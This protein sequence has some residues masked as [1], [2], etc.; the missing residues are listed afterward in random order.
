MLN[1]NQS[2]RAC[3]SAMSET[4]HNTE[5]DSLL[6]FMLNRILKVLNGELDRALQ[7]HGLSMAEWRVLATLGFTAIDRPAAIAQFTKIDPSTLSR[8]FDRLEAQGYVARAKPNGSRR[9]FRFSLT[10]GGRQALKR[11]AKIVRLQH[12]HMLGL[13]SKDQ[14]KPFLRSISALYL[15][16]GRPPEL[17]QTKP[18]T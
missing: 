14:I 16:V 3:E 15:A 1:R 8:T 11:A 2:L 18:V 13:L 10:L 17:L 4:Q 6:P 12:D 9:G 5:L 7:A